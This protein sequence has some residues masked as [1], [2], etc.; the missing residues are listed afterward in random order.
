LSYHPE[1]I[2]ELYLGLDM[3]E[4]DKADILQKANAVNPAIAVLQMKR[5]EA[6]GLAWDSTART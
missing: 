2:T 5:N 1:E 3:D 6:G 4:T